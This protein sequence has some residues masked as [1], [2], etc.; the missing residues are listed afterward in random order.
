MNLVYFPKERKEEL[1]LKEMKREVKKKQ[2]KLVMEDQK[3]LMKMKLLLSGPDEDP[4][5]GSRL[6]TPKF[7]AAASGELDIS[8]DGEEASISLTILNRNIKELI[9]AR[10]RA[11]KV[12]MAFPQVVEE[13]E[14]KE[15]EDKEQEKEERKYENFLYRF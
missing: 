8:K 11:K 3:V 12:A 6:T 4:R 10:A 9:I 1:R 13:K 15:E 2:M 7:Q 5:N 14:K